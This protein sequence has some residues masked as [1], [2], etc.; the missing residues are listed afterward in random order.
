MF[1]RVVW[2][3]IG[4]AV[5]AAGTVWAEQK[6]RSQLDRARPAQLAETARRA[7]RAAIDEG[8]TV[9]S[10]REGELRSRLGS[11][12]PSTGVTVLRP[13]DDRVPHVRR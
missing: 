4:S 12:H 7:V 1:K 8:R 2:F 3:G 10:E 5:G 9:A 13:K 11:G 6:V